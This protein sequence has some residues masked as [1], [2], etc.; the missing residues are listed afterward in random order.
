MQKHGRAAGDGRGFEIAGGEQVK[1]R[2]GEREL[3]TRER[4]RE[5]K[6]ST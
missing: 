1:K 2:E 5:L 6:T 3:T 4:E